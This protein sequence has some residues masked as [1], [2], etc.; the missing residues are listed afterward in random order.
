MSKKI[1]E[2]L[3]HKQHNQTKSN[4]FELT[5]DGGNPGVAFNQAYDLQTL[6]PVPVW[7]RMYQEVKSEIRN[8]GLATL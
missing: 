7:V 4:Q 8:M 2:M 6:T 1:L 5:Q 3:F